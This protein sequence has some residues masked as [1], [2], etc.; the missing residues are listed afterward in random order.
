LKNVGRTGYADGNGHDTDVVGTVAARDNITGVVGVAPAARPRART[1]HR[2]RMASP[3]MM[4][5]SMKGSSTSVSI[6]S[7]GHSDPA[8]HRVGADRVALVDQRE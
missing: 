1:A 4:M 5:D 8:P 6:R 2:F 7:N 3:G